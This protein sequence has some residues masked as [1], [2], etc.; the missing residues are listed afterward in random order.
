[1]ATYQKVVLTLLL[2]T[3]ITACS[4]KEA[5]EKLNIER[6]SLMSTF[7]TVET[8]DMT[9]RMVTLRDSEGKAFTIHAGEE[10][11]N[12]P[13]VRPGDRVDVTYSE[14]LSVRMAEPGEAI[15]EITGIIG[16]A[17][18]G[19]KP[20]AVDVTETSI[21]ATIEA[22]DKANETATLQ[23]E[24]GSRR[25]VKVQDPANLE[26]VKVG[27]RIVIVYQEAVGI[28]VEGKE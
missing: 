4:N 28:F 24:D 17:E 1:M 16:R 26:L 6:S 20:A 9:T 22:I 15:N 7:A 8:V 19:E 11:V 12:L 14:S 23:M 13:Q 27:D 25:I 18:P 21:T 2:A 3:T 10:V 5:P